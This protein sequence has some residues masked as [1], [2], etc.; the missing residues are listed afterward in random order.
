M[1][2]KHQDVRTDTLKK[3]IETTSDGMILTIDFTVTRV[4]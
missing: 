1:E 2:D 4:R 3:K